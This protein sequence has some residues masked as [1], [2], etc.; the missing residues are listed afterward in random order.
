MADLFGVDLH[1]TID[2]AFESESKPAEGVY[3]LKSVLQKKSQA[4][5]MKSY[6]WFVVLPTLDITDPSLVVGDGINSV[7]DAVKFSNGEIST[8]V[9]QI[10]NPMPTF[11]T[12]KAH[13]FNS[14]WYRASRNDIGNIQ[15]EVEEYEDGLTHQYFE[16]WMKMMVNTNGTYNPPAA[17]KKN[18]HLVRLSASKRDL[19]IFKYKGCFISDVADVSNDYE[20]SNIVKYTYNMTL[21]ELDVE[22]KNVAKF[23][24]S[25]DD[26]QIL[27]NALVDSARDVA[28]NV[29]DSIATALNS[30]LPPRL[31]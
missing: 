23:K 2:K 17:Y 6:L 30:R 15:L 14:Y 24:E 13:N 28:T 27:K 8:R 31:Q 1:N 20:T 4:N 7:E 3:D 9:S 11:E 29:S 12:Q 5:P 16:A 10:T 25:P 22:T 19:Q 18:I 21:D 26:L